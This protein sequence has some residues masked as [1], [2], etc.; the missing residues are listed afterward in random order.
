MTIT[1]DPKFVTSESQRRGEISWL[2]DN[3]KKQ[4]RKTPQIWQRTSTYKFKKLSEF[5]NRTY[6]KRSM[7]RH[8]IIKLLKNK[9]KKNLENSQ[10]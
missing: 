10:R 5:P 3:S 4:W 9:D 1:K 2:K 8:T 6:P 7:L